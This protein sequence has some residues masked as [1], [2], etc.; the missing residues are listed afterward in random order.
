VLAGGVVLLVAEVVSHLALQGTL[1]HR[2]GQLLQEAVVTEHIFG[3][4]VVFQ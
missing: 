1:D 4:L 3:R 2:L